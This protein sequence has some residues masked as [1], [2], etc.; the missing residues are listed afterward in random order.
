LQTLDWFGG[1]GILRVIEVAEDDE[2]GV[3][4]GGE[5]GVN[6]LPQEP[7]FYNC[8]NVTAQVAATVALHHTPL[9]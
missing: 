9:S 5:A 6:L 3:G 7:G 2:V 1:G 4:I 8:A